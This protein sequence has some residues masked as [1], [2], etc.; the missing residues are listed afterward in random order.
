MKKVKLTA[1]ALKEFAAY[2]AHCF[3]V[4]IEFTNLIFMNLYECHLQA[5]KEKL[6]RKALDFQY[7]GKRE[8]TLKLTRAE[9]L[10]LSFLFQQIPCGGF[11]LVI[12]AQILDGLTLIS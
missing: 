4:E 10:T 9:V 6:H 8:I 2:I 7:S 3:D 12:Q 1:D 11:M 5:I